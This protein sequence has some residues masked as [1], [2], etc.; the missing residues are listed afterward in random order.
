[1]SIRNSES[2]EHNHVT[3]A[4]VFA[5]ARYSAYVDDLAIPLCFFEDQ[6]TGFWPK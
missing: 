5:T 4:A 3:S 2:K 6:E 1:M